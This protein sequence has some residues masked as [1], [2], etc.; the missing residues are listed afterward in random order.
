MIKK[1][2]VISDRQATEEACVLGAEHEVVSVT[3]MGACALITYFE[4]DDE[5]E[6]GWFGC[7]EMAN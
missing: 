7:C 5:E 3:R 6:K 2:A 4:T 1:I